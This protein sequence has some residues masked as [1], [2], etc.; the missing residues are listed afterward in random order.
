MLD[1]SGRLELH[2]LPELI[3]G[4]PGRP[5]EA[6]TLYPVAC[7][8]QAWPAGAYFLLLQSCLGLSIRARESRI[9]L[10]HTARPEALPRVEIRNLRVGEASVD[11][12]FERHVHTV[13]IDIFRRSGEVEIAA[14]R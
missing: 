9:Y 6:P 3:C 4:F 11:L 13:G 2:R 7:S 10:R 14:L 5:G 1:L 8:P 12:A